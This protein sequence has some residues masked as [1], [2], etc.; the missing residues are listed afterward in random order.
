MPVNRS[1]SFVRVEIK[2][3]LVFC[4]GGVCFSFVVFFKNFISSPCENSFKGHFTSMKYVPNLHVLI[5]FS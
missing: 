4:F 5:L 1:L 2:S 3:W